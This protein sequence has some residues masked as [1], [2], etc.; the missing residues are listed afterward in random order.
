MLKPVAAGLTCTGLLA[1]GLS[2]AGGQED[3]GA[4]RQVVEQAPA[5]PRGA[6]LDP[7]TRATLDKLARS[8][9]ETAS[10]LHQ[11]QKPGEAAEKLQ[12]MRLVQMLLNWE[13]RQA[14]LS[15]RERPGPPQVQN[16][17]AGRDAPAQADA[18][19]RQIVVDRA[20][21]ALSSAARRLAVVEEQN[22]DDIARA[23]A[24]HRLA[25]LALKNYSEGDIVREKNL[26]QGR[27]EVAQEE[28][29][30]ARDKYA[31]TQA[32]AT[33]DLSLR[34]AVEA[35]RIAATKALIQLKLAEEEM[36]ILMEFSHPRQMAELQS[37]VETSRRQLNL[38]KLRAQA[39]ATDMTD[40]V[41]IAKRE[42]EL[43]KTDPARLSAAESR[44]F[45]GGPDG[46]TAS[47]ATIER[48]LR[49]LQEQFERLR[50][51]VD[52][53]RESVPRRQ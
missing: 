1:L 12:S 24:S 16:P 3:A 21:A 45:P 52:G 46:D 13:A 32:A 30:R 18:L 44:T 51:E 28:H 6:R 41:S 37:A 2:H 38:A 39:A 22:E 34:A 53:L 40:R 8:L 31:T 5:I 26:L 23:D 19:A 20:A 17:A 43:A 50:K 27:I 25:Q 49:E 9:E 42:W 15:Q 33:K 7:E 29:T 48:S 11:E 10:R 35:D 47:P 4:R 14:G 36:K